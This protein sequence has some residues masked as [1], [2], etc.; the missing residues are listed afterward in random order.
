MV[1]RLRALARAGEM[2]GDRCGSALVGLSMLSARAPPPCG[3]GGRA[4]H[5]TRLMNVAVAVPFLIGHRR[6]RSGALEI[7]GVPRG[8]F[9]EQPW[10]SLI[11]ER[12]RRPQGPRANTPAVFLLPAAVLY[13]CRSPAGR[14][15]PLRRRFPVQERQGRSVSLPS[16]HDPRCWRWSPWPIPSNPASGRPLPALRALVRAAQPAATQRWK[17]RCVI[18]NDD[19]MAATRD[20]ALSRRTFTVLVGRTSTLALGFKAFF[21]GA[22]GVGR[23]KHVGSRV[24]PTWAPKAG[25]SCTQAEDTLRSTYDPPT[26]LIGA[27]AGI[28]ALCSSSRRSPVPGVDGVL[29]GAAIETPCPV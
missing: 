20:L 8:L 15:R 2:G 18:M 12:W 7:R 9:A 3:S 21:P 13:W 25:D 24:L 29:G 5:P 11:L 16:R 1:S 14:L 22:H 6:T 26:G 17:C 10:R 27:D 23:T 4:E 28:C 19:L